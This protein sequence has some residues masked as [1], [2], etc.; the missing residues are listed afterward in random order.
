MKNKSDFLTKFI[1]RKIAVIVDDVSLDTRRAVLTC[2]A[3]DISDELINEVISIAP[4]VVFASLGE[5][6][7]KE[8]E[9]KEM[10]RTNP[11]DSSNRTLNPRMCTSV[12]ARYG[13]T[14]GISADDR[15][16]CLRALALDNPD[17][18]QFVK[19]GHIVPIIASD[20]GVLAK[21]GIPEASLDLVKLSN[22][23][24]VACFVDLLSEGKAVDDTFLNSLAENYALPVFHI[25]DLIRY[26]LATEIM[27]TK[28]AEA[29][30]PTK[31]G[32][33][34]KSC[35]I[36]IKGHEAEHMALIKG[37][38][39]PEQPITVRVQSEST[40]DDVFG[41]KTNSHRLSLSDSLKILDKSENGIFLYLRKNL[42]P[43]TDVTI[44]PSMTLMREYG[45]GAQILHSLGVR[46]LHLISNS[47][48]VLGGLDAFGL[49]ILSQ[50]STKQALKELG[51]E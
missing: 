27:V 32:G 36:K 13:I 6:L 37:K 18:S 45:V 29:K 19:P 2:P 41:S 20:E 11:S 5:L 25:S 14:T 49:E 31:L 48:K 26:R 7:V 46:K 17:P 4:G 9:F 44:S 24:K 43:Q 51:E 39:S 33:M 15:A 3:K 38:I 8:L 42:A 1:F 21:P 28:V 12:D 16:K 35:V 23:G 34:L 10:S 30:L 40:I 50:R 47:K 22:L